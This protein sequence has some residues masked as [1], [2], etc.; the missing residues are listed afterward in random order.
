MKIFFEGKEEDLKKVKEYI[1]KGFEEAIKENKAI[2]FSALNFYRKIDLNGNKM[3]F[4]TNFFDVLKDLVG[5]NRIL[6]S[7]FGYYFDRAKKVF[8]DRLK[9]VI[10][11]EKLN[12]NIVKVEL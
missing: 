5:E 7:M 8:V 6:K 1:E 12:V 3:I 4:E 10:S 11:K 9:N 2:N